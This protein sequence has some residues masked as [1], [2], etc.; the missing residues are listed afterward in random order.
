MK[1]TTDV[2]KAAYVVFTNQCE[3]SSSRFIQFCMYSFSA[4]YYQVPILVNEPPPGS[5]PQSGE[6]LCYLSASLTYYLI[7]GLWRKAISFPH[8]AYTAFMFHESKL[9]PNPCLL[10]IKKQPLIYCSIIFYKNF[11]RN[12]SNSM[13][14]RFLKWKRQVYQECLKAQ[15]QSSEH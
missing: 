6:E 11:L 2:L 12:Q 14:K 13:Q 8:L 4:C 15:S 9:S 3:S 1:T 5:F 10:V 7:F